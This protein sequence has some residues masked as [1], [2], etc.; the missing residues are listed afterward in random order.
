MRSQAK[1]SGYNLTIPQQKSLGVAH[2]RVL[3]MESYWEKLTF[4]LIS[5][6][7]QLQVQCVSLCGEHHW[8]VSH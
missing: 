6:E 3:A 1:A 7:T 8:V 5:A 4:S 2:G